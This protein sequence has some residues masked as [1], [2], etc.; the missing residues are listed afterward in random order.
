MEKDTDKEYLLD[1]VALKQYVQ[2]PKSELNVNRWIEAQI[3]KYGLACHEAPRKGMNIQELTR[4]RTRLQEGYD[5]IVNYLF[6]MQMTGNLEK[7]DP[8]VREAI[9]E[10]LKY[11]EE[12]EA[13]SD[14][15]MD[16]E[17][18]KTTEAMTNFFDMFG[19]KL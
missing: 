3:I 11:R 14:E 12:L 19:V 8:E 15:L 9:G 17:T 18:K 13:N 10:F 2:D 4:V 1:P 6:V 5:L 7:V 16:A